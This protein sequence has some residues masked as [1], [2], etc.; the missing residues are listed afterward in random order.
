MAPNETDLNICPSC[1]GKIIE[2]EVCLECGWSGLPQDIYSLE[3]LE[4]GVVLKDRYEVIERL[5]ASG[6]RIKG[7]E[8]RIGG[9]NCYLMMDKQSERTVMVKE[10]AIPIED[11]KSTWFTPVNLSSQ[12]N[13]ESD[14][15]NETVGVSEEIDS[16]L[17]VNSEFCDRDMEIEEDAEISPEN[18]SPTSE[19]D[20]AGDYEL[21]DQQNLQRDSLTQLRR[22]A[23]LLSFKRLQEERSILEELEYPTV[24]KILDYFED[25]GRAYLVEEYFES[26]VLWEAWHLPDTSMMQRIDWLIQ[27]CQALA[28]VHEAN[29]L[30]N[31]VTP[32]R[33]RVSN[34]NRLVLTDFSSAV[35]LPLGEK[36]QQGVDFYV[37]PELVLELETVDIRADLYSLGVMWYELLLDR[38][39]TEEDFECQFILK[40]LQDYVPDL[41]PTINQ[42]LLK[43]T[44]HN[45]DLRFAS[46]DEAESGKQPIVSL[47]RRLLEFKQ[48]LAQPTLLVGSRTDV[49]L[50][51]PSN[52]DNFWAQNLSYRRLDG[53]AP[54][55]LF[56]VADGMGGAE[57]GEVAS[58]IVI[59][60][61]SDTLLSELIVLRE[62]FDDDHS[63]YLL[64]QIRDAII[65][66]NQE[67][68]AQTEQVPF[69]RGMGSTVTLAAIVGMRAYVG[70][71]GDSRLY[72]LNKEE[73]Q[74][75]TTDHSIVSR[76]LQI[77]AITPEE[78]ETH[79]QRD[80][81]L[82]AVGAR[83]DIEPDTFSFEIKRG[84]ILLLCSD[85]L[86]KH[87]ED[88]E[89]HQIVMD[90][91]SPQQACDSLVNHA[92]LCGGEDNITVIVIQVVYDT[93]N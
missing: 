87:Q 11:D 1:E 79:P 84:D 86:T 33:L 19:P 76:L 32:N 29:V 39:L 22:Q 48:S 16:V 58:K 24:I 6:E 74:R 92:N 26:C 85:G 31:A 3:P 18:S 73:I 72:L 81:L 17:D 77:G 80:V 66:A 5:S 63:E 8:P 23:Q 59:Q 57:A 47:Q 13:E 91:S 37:A 34:E 61:I 44:H 65:S 4:I 43:L 49:G 55:G 67:I 35:K 60:T 54:M 62:C 56:I 78:A 52:E 9:I 41:H 70:H 2:G 14:C 21:P 42:L 88:A 83:T 93:T 27:L 36:H 38:E 40:P 20:S 71:V 75:K 28:K 90:A 15:H 68:I 12:L 50:Q 30:Y 25:D 46:K 89:I 7:F 45:P 53:Y 10:V 64:P 69:W 82:K 51:R